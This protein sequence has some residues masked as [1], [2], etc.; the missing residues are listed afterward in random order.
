MSE[1]EM[2]EQLVEPEND[3]KAESELNG[4]EEAAPAVDPPSNSGGN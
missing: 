4:A 1:K 2:D 3:G